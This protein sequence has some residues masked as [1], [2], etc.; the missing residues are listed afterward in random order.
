VAIG[1]AADPGVVMAWRR[2]GK[3]IGGP[4]VRQSATWVTG[5]IDAIH[6]AAD[7]DAAD[8]LAFSD[9]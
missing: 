4:V 7:D 3:A 8:D 2:P 6:G 1:D 5:E 9:V